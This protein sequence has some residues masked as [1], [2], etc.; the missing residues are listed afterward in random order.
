MTAAPFPVRIVTGADA[1]YFA[2][3]GLLTQSLAQWLPTAPPP[4]VCD[5]GLTPAQRRFF[6]AAGRL[7]PRPDAV[8]EG[9][10]PYLAKAALAD[11]LADHRDGEDVPLLWID[12]DMMATT[13]RTIRAHSSRRREI[14]KEVCL[15]TEHFPFQDWFWNRR[16]C[17]RT[18]QAVIGVPLPRQFVSKWCCLWNS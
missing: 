10:H 2:M 8:A 7:L 11:Y 12:G 5:F 9:T 17:E 3:V 6:A 18:A 4:L 15:I 1:R 14:T 16:G 13:M